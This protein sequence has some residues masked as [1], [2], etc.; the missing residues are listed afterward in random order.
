MEFVVIGIGAI[1]LGR[2]PNGLV[3]FAFRGA[4][5]LAPRL[6]VPRRLHVFSSAPKPMVVAEAAQA[7][8]IPEAQ[9]AGHGVA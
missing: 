7:D 8:E 5:A 9:V 1:L 3:N 4:R 6:P 2:D